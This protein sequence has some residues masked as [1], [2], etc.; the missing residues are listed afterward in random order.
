[1]AFKANG[2]DAKGKPMDYNARWVDTYVKMPDGKWQCVLSQGSDGLYPSCTAV[3][4]SRYLSSTAVA[5]L[6]ISVA[7]DSSPGVASAFNDIC[8]CLIFIEG[9]GVSSVLSL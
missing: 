5:A 3:L 2:T 4:S 1:M 9:T 8:M 7:R 6:R